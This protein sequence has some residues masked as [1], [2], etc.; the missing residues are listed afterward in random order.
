MQNLRWT[1]VMILVVMM[2]AT[3]FSGCT[4]KAAQEPV[5]KAT[6][7]LD[8]V[9]STGSTEATTQVEK[10]VT[11]ANVGVLD[12]APVPSLAGKVIGIAVIGTTNNF[13]RTAYQAMIDRVTVLGGTPV[14]VDG[15]RNDQKH[16]ADI[17]NLV[18]QGVDA[19]V[20][21]LGDAAIYEPVLK[22]VNEKGIPLFTVDHPSVYSTC[23]A[24]SDNY[25]I[26]S[27]LART[28]FEDMGGEG[29]V[30]VFN[31]FYGVRAP[32]I[33][34][35]MLKYVAMDY[36]KVTFLDPDLQDITPGTVEDSY[37]KIQDLLASYPEGSELKAI[38]AAWDIPGIGAA[39]ALDALGRKDVK[40]YGIDGDPTALEM[41]KDP[42]SCFQAIMCQNPKLIGESIIDQAARSLAG[43]T[44]PSSVYVEP[45]LVTK[46]NY[47]FALVKLYGEQ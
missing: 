14:A 21:M 47:N 37:K 4:I 44:V 19:I 17:E 2:T 29:M 25:A 16:I 30:A 24:T 6:E 13:D 32:A 15:E 34:Y 3:L 22:K 45:V 23:N 26:G 43:Q 12:G 1:I 33:R 27:T 7:V 46:E 18:T 28:I 35:D 42:N 36:P 31:G 5:A 11:A 8:S 38:T 39:Q 40:V 20:K 41:V 10:K 9:D